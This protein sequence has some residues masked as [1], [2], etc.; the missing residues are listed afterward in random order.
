M[1]PSLNG[2][3]VAARSLEISE[4]T[5]RNLE[6]AGVVKAVRDSAGRRQFT[7]EQI[8]ILRRHIAT[9]GLNRAA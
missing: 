1:Q 8:E 4:D 6:R 9:R 5:V 2:V 3:S 7:V